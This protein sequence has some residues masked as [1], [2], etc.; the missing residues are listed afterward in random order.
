MT[1]MDFV[2]PK[3][4]AKC[5]LLLNTK[6]SSSIVKTNLAIKSFITLVTGIIVVQ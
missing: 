4:A 3:A 6:D 1:N 5:E 2:P